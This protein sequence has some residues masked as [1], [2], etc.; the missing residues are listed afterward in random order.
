MT[1]VLLNYLSLESGS[2]QFDPKLLSRCWRRKRKGGR[3]KT[4]CGDSRVLVDMA[5]IQ[6]ADRGNFEADALGQ[7]LGNP[8]ARRGV[9]EK[10]RA[11][12]LRPAVLNGQEAA[13]RLKSR[14]QHD[15]GENAHL[16]DRRA[17]FLAAI[18]GPNR[19]PGRRVPQLP[20]F[21][22]SRLGDGVQVRK[23]ASELHRRDSTIAARRNR[24]GCKP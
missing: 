18:P 12:V 3:R 24:I 14:R 2:G 9:V 10:Q 15:V 19:R 8:A 20:G 17:E 22:F 11:D 21:R 16:P 23:G 6:I 7:Q 13:V 4:R 1:N 5:H